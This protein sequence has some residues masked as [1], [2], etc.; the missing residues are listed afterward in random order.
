MQTKIIRYCFLFFLIAFYVLYSGCAQIV[1]PSGGPKDMKAP[2]AEKY[3]PDS[4]ATNFSA[5]TITIVF[6]EYIQLQD[7]QK[8]MTISPP[9]RI[10]PEV[11]AK[12]KTLQIELN[13]TLKKNTTY[14]INFGS[15]IR[16]FT[17]SN[18]KTDFRYIFSTGSYIDTLK[19]T[20]IVKNAY[21]QKTEKGILV[22]LYESGEDSVPYKTGPSYFAKTNADGTYKIS[23][24]RP[25]TYK[26]FALKDANS[27]YRFDLP[28]ESIGFSDTLIRITRNVKHDLRIFTEEPAKQRLLK[29]FTNG[30]ARM[31]LIYSKPVSVV[32]Y[33][34]L[35]STT[36]TE[37]FLTEYNTGRDSIRIWF[38]SFTKDTLYFKVI[39]DG[40]TIDTVRIGTGQFQKG[41]GGRGEAFKLTAT[42]N[43]KKDVPFDLHKSVNL[44]FNHPIPVSGFNPEKISLLSASKIEPNCID[45]TMPTPPP[46]FLKIWGA[47][48]SLDGD[49]TYRLFVPPGSFTDIFGL[50]NDSID[51]KFKVKEEKYYGTLK[52]TL[53][54]KYRIA[55]VLE[56]VNEKGQAIQYDRSERGIFSYV[57]LN[58]GS[59]KLRIIYDQNGDGKWTTGNYAEKRRPETI[60]YYPGAV[61][62][63]SNWDLELDWKLD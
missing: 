40:T 20:G 3:I 23:N 63:R 53:K 39:A 7:L 50:Q 33:K 27:N 37:T 29:N 51:I 38:P 2:F 26:V 11:K 44:Y 32:S 58:P 9:M 5:K 19:L 36:R 12:G 43:V 16:D 15:A 45:S 4:A 41:S 35:N 17:E 56:L 54:M 22:M 47:T 60:I 30:Y 18:A 14:V 61:T 1:V 46:A 28:S 13:D 10:Q 52:L 24:I 55:Y 6:D 8:E 34:P 42:A 49:S 57:F 59:Y 62:I 25:G 48:C 31:M 21:D